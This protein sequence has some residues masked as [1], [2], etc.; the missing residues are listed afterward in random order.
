MILVLADFT[1]IHSIRFRGK[2]MATHLQ[3]IIWQQYKIIKIYPWKKHYK[4][5]K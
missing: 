2:A 3:C 1:L 5:D 4:I